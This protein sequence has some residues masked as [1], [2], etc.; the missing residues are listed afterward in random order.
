MAFPNIF[1]IYD[2][3]VEHPDKGSLIIGRVF[4]YDIEIELKDGRKSFSERY[5]EDDAEKYI[6]QKNK[7]NYISLLS[8]L[9]KIKSDLN[10]HPDSSK[11]KGQSKILSNFA[12][13][14]VRWFR[15]NDI[16]LVKITEPERLTKEQEFIESF[17]KLYDNPNTTE[18]EVRSTLYDKNYFTNPSSNMRIV[19]DELE[20]TTVEIKKHP[21]FAFLDPKGT[22]IS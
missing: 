7:K 16:E 22:A 2:Q 4:D 5:L 1:R 21:A 8:D 3:V 19:R 10:N 15:Q 6:L 13:E 9:K 14:F 12:G 18:A 17:K 20:L 11:I